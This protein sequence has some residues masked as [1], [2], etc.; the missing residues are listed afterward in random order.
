MS[1]RAYALRFISGKYQ[2]GEYPLA[3]SGE[4]MRVIVPPVEA[5]RERPRALLVK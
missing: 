2:G 5:T 3:E 1:D 4:P